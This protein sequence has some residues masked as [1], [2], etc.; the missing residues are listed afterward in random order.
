MRILS[1]VL[2]I[3][4]SSNAAIAQTRTVVAGKPFKLH[5][6]YATN[7]DCSSMGDVVI[8]VVSPPSNGRVSIARGGA[9]PN[10]APPNV[11]SDCNRRR[12]PATIATYTAQR[13]YTGPDSVS[14]EIIYPTGNVRQTSY[15][16]M[17]R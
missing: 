5:A 17:V 12:V 9:F 14:L 15:S 10:F 1:I 4:F 11:R 3:L 16:L 6:A 13:G 2:M 8:R 7:P